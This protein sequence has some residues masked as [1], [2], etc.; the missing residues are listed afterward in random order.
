VGS[1]A[2]NG[3][4]SL[5]SVLPRGGSFEELP[6]T[7]HDQSCKFLLLFHLKYILSAKHVMRTRGPGLRANYLLALLSTRKSHYQSIPVW[8]DM[9]GSSFVYSRTIFAHGP[10]LCSWPFPAHVKVWQY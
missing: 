8:R 10:D 2:K 5:N 3:A 6:K 7:I 9:D 1:G 4:P